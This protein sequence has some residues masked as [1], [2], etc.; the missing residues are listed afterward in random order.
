MTRS[1]RQGLSSSAKVGFRRCADGAPPRQ[2][3]APRPD[4]TKM[5]RDAV[6]LYI[7]EVSAAL[8]SGNYNLSNARETEER[9]REIRRTVLEKLLLEKL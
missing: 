1:R 7:D 4:I 3:A 9:N 5:I 2:I 6:R 8:E